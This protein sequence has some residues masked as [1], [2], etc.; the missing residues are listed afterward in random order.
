MESIFHLDI[1]SAEKIIYSGKIESL[2]VPSQSGYAG[3]LANH[4]PFVAVLKTGV[5]T[6]RDNLGHSTVFNLS[7][8]GLIEV[9]KNKATLLIDSA[10]QIV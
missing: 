4:A 10:S 5:I 1:V 3:I 9:L 7:G 2:I 8:K 6:L